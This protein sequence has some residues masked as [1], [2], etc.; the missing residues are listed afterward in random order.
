M[1]QQQQIN[2]KIDFVDYLDI[3]SSHLAESAVAKSRF[4]SRRDYNSGK[5]QLPVSPTGDNAR[6]LGTDSHKLQL[7]KASFFDGSDEEMNEICERESNRASLLLPGRKSSARCFAD[8]AQKLD[9]NENTR[10]RTVRCYDR[11]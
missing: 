2:S 3:D 11:I 9:E 7:M 10:Y 5:K 6:I 8:T 1:V 4:S